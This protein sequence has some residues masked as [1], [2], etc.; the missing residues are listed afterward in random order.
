MNQ[1]L[2][3]PPQTSA[4]SGPTKMPLSGIVVLLAGTIGLAG[5]MFAR[6]REAQAAK[7]TIAEQRA[8]DSKR[9]LEELKAVRRVEVVRGSADTWAPVVEIDGTLAAGQSADIGFK[10][11]GRLQSLSVSIGAAVKP[12][13]LLATLDASEASAQLA[14][15]K[16]QVRASEA[17][18]ALAEDTERRTAPLVQSGAMAAATGVQTSQQTALSSAQLE[19]AKAQ[20]SLA[21]VALGNHRLVAPFAGTITKAPDGLGSVVG[22]GVPLFQISSLGTLK[23]QGT[24]G[25]EDAPLLEKGAPIQVI[26]EGESVTGTITTV[27][28]TVD[29][30]TRRVRVEAEVP[31]PSGRL[32]AGTFVR[33]E[34][35]SGA[36]IPI[37]RLP[38]DVLRPGSQNELLIVEQGHLASRRIAF[39]FA[40]SG[41]L[42]VR[43][44]LSGGDLV[45]RNPKPEDGA[46]GLVEIDSAPGE[47]QAAP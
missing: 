10:V 47:P 29:Q 3:E 23:L 39:S 45:V 35:R 15:A 13:Q 5:W 34:V 11:G 24:V 36:G 9:Q 22:P 28:G 37:L 41:E 1:P 8:V 12:G 18:L 14:A 43:H 19:A 2:P 46:G 42:L 38:H 20:L 6:V 32:R 17:G 7:D 33:A 30:S 26:S 27:L 44:G 31:N 16:A 40:P 21:Q 25:V 4:P